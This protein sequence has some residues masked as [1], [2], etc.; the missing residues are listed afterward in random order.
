MVEF[1]C[2]YRTSKNAK[3]MVE[4][5]EFVI[6]EESSSGLPTVPRWLPAMLLKS[7]RGVEAQI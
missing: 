7:C 6:G 3:E 5:P 2:T 1:L 4:N